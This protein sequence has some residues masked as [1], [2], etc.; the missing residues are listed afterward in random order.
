MLDVLSEDYIRTAKAK[1]VENRSMLLKHALKNAGVPIATVVGIGVALLMSGVVITET[2][3]NIPGVGRLVVDAIS[4]RDYPIIQGVI[5][6]FAGR[7]RADQPCRRPH[8]H[9]DRP[10]D[11]V[12]MR[13][14]LLRHRE[15]PE[16]DAAIQKV[17]A[18]PDCFAAMLL[19]MTRGGRTELAR[20]PLQAP[21]PRRARAASGASSGATPRCRRAAIL[22]VMALIAIFAPWIAGDPA[23]HPAGAAPA[24]ALRA[25]LARHRRARPRRLRPHRLRRAGVPDGWPDCRRDRGGGVGL[26]I[27]LVA[28]LL[29]P[30]ADAITHALIMDGLM[31]IPAILLAIALVSLT[32]ASITTVIVAIM[33]PEIP[34]VVRL[35]RSVV[36]SV[37]EQPFVEAAVAAARR[38]GKS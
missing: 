20:S 22:V 25:V 38:P 8:L 14:L 33:I 27:G 28:G 2:V 3:F 35:V 7:L 17:R 23:A 11:T 24:A 4:K 30:P 34:R 9:A 19:A 15:R 32:R 31:A 21:C 5:L 16:A 12:L 36:L 13:T 6:I 26:A 29:L 1:G 18:G 37:R 10:E